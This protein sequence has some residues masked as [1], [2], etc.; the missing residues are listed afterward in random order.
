MNTNQSCV[1]FDQD[2]PF[3]VDQIDFIEKEHVNVG[4]SYPRRLALV[5]LI[6]IKIKQEVSLLA[7]DVLGVVMV[8]SL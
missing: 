4:G 1:S 5:S 8:E 7:L 6:L 3:V 2:E